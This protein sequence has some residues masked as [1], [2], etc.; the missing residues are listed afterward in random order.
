MATPV[1]LPFDI[2]DNAVLRYDTPGAVDRIADALLAAAAA[3]EREYE[4]HV[5][6][7]A[8]R[9]TSDAIFTLRVLADLQRRNPPQP[10]HGDLAG[11]IF[12]DDHNAR[13]R[14]NFVERELLIHRLVRMQHVHNQ[15]DNSEI[16][17]LHPTALGTRVLDLKWP[18]TAAVH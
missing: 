14:Y 2:K 15:A 3:F 10:I 18:R 5:R 16:F 11:K 13:L 17:A 6:E 9:L 1:R 4:L 8:E 7:V 12:V